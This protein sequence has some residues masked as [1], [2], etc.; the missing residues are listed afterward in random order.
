[1]NRSPGRSPI[2]PD[3]RQGASVRYAFNPEGPAGDV[4]VVIFLRGAADALNMVVPYA[5][6]AYY[7]LRPTLGIARPDDS[8]ASAAERVLDLDGFFGLHPAL[9][10]L[11]R[12]WD[13]ELLAIVHATGAPDESRSHF[14]SMELMERGATDSSGP[15]SGW[16]ARY[17]ARSLP[18]SASP[19]R[20]VAWGDRPMRSLLGSVPVTTLQSIADA[21]LGSEAAPLRAFQSALDALYRPIDSLGVAGQEVLRLMGSLE[22]LQGNGSRSP[23][24]YPPT[25]YGR[26]LEQ[27]AR[28]IHAEVGLEV[29]ALDLGGWD[30][31]FAQ[32][33]SQGLMAGL[34]AELATGLSAFFLDLG[35]AAAGVTLIT[36]SEFGRRAYENG[37]LG[38]DHGHG[39]CIFV[40]GGGVQGGRVYGRWP[41][42][43]EGQLFGPGDLAVTTDYRDVLAEICQR[44]LGRSS[45]EETFPGHDLKPVGMIA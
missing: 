11:R 29:A 39:S 4:L 17:L 35:P 9:A 8:R 42:L 20:A 34:L 45:L 6:A 19:L 27:T 21:H 28:L 32:G 1:M 3:A 36:M 22:R 37:S 10:P 13:E 38:T 12:V 15:A 5:D 44:R 18:S 7:A 30:T 2:R 40:L 43:G 24:A 25:E 31:H 23:Q 16:L 26:A 14:L 33:G 41:G